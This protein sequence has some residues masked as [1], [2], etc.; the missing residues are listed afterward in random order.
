MG[1]V[2]SVYVAQLFLEDEPI[3]RS[4]I[5]PLAPKFPVTSMSRSTW[6]GV[7]GADLHLRTAPEQTRARPAFLTRL[8]ASSTT[9]EGDLYHGVVQPIPAR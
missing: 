4:S 3:L 6:M 5:I 8:L 7:E 9:S 1:P 2:P